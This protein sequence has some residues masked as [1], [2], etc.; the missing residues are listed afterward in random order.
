M[1]KIELFIIIFL[2]FFFLSCNQQVVEKS[3]P[4]ASCRFQNQSDF[5]SRVY[6]NTVEVA[7][8]PQGG[9]EDIP[10]FDCSLLYDLQVALCEIDTASADTT[11]LR[12]FT[13]RQ[14]F[15][16]GS[17]YRIDITNEKLESDYVYQP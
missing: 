14:H 3:A 9:Y 5:Y 17:F 15:P 13:Q 6:I 7:E 2:F 4:G 10:F 8:I 11:I 12:T 1:K 16:A